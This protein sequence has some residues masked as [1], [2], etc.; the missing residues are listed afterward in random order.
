MS[1]GS[2]L[3]VSYWLIQI[4][5]AVLL[6]YFSIKILVILNTLSPWY[7]GDLPYVPSDNRLMKQAFAML[8]VRKGDR[9]VDLGSGDG[10]FLIYGARKIDAVF[11]GVE[12]NSFL[13]AL[14]TVK[15]KLSLKRGSVNIK[16]ASFWNEDL[17]QY[18]RLFLFNM[19]SVLKKLVKKFD[20]ELKRGVLVVS[21]MFPIESERLKLIDTQGKKDK[22][23][24]YEV[25]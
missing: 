7:K 3:L 11:V 21:V 24:L 17:S 25:V 16:K 18:D 14:S 13:W 5:M 20:S 2:V 9:V 19:P 15:S 8:D 12:I 23:F 1:F 6:L 4:V 10:K 22:V